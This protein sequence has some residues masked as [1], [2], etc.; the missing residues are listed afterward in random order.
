MWNR[1]C[2]SGLL[3]PRALDIEGKNCFP[4]SWPTRSR[5]KYWGPVHARQR[6]GW[7]GQ[8]WEEGNMLLRTS[9]LGLFMTG[10]KRKH[11]ILFSEKQDLMKKCPQTHVVLVHIDRNTETRMVTSLHVDLSPHTRRLILWRP[12]KRDLKACRKK[13]QGIWGS[14]GNCLILSG[15]QFLPL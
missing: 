7:T 10:V 9:A 11:W 14:R 8:M 4:V 12:H 6:S 1:A 13:E 2:K 15:P 5:F 3:P